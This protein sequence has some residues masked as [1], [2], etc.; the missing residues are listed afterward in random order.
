MVR[1]AEAA[2]LHLVVARSAFSRPAVTVQIGLWPVS[3][4]V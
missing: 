3:T 4:A 1:L 2:D